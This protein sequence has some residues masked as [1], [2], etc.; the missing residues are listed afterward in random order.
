MRGGHE[1]DSAL[2]EDNPLLSSRFALTIVAT[3]FAAEVLGVN[4]YSFGRAITDGSS[5]ED[6]NPRY[7]V[8]FR[9]SL[10]HS[11][12]GGESGRRD[13]AGGALGEREHD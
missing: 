11:L 2:V 7:D 12:I 9:P 13:L 10:P 1:V 6:R 4:E 5:P 8:S 3:C